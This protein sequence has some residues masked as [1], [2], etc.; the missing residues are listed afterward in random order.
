MTGYCFDCAEP[1]TSTVAILT[2]CGYEPWRSFEKDYLNSRKEAYYRDKQRWTDALIEKAQ[3]HVIP[4]LKEMV[5]VMEAGSPLTDL[6]YTGNP[7]GAIYGFEQ[8]MDNSFMKRMDNNRTPI[9][10]LYLAGAW[11]FPGGGFEGLMRSG[12]MTFQHIM[13]DMADDE[14]HIRNFIK[15]GL[16]P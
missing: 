14:K 11:G 15:T 2:I 5:A 4:G 6:S 9:K 7:D 10:G 12:E 1:G 13:E 3:T 8:S 16:K